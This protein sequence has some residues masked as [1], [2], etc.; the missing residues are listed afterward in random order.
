MSATYDGHQSDTSLKLRNLLTD[1]VTS[2]QSS[3][4][5]SKISKLDYKKS[6]NYDFCAIFPSFCMLCD[7]YYIC[8]LVK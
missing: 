7:I 5:R 3:D 1:Y 6:S 4:V 8:K 2:F